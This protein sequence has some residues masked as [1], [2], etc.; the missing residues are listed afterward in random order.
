MNRK[1]LA[2]T[3]SE[4]G[5]T[6]LVNLFALNKKGDRRLADLPGY[7]YAKVGWQERNRWD[8]ELS[9]YLQRRISLK[10]VV[11]VMDSR[12]PMTELDRMMISLFLGGPMPFHVLLNKSDKLSKN[13]RKVMID[14]VGRELKTLSPDI[15]LSS[16]SSPNR[17]G[18]GE[19]W[20]V[21][22]RWLLP[23]PPPHTHTHSE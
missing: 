2:R 15:G 5:K 1:S 6:R 12:H 22:N 18:I 13:Q 23:P 4:P 16:F 14:R 10:G 7:G 11:I 17:E 20:K 19:L 3:S 8:E 21:L 9:L